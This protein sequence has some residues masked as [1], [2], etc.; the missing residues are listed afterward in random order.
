M[1]IFLYGADTFRSRQ[2]LNELKDK[3]IREVDP[4][5]NSLIAL[6]GRDVKM[7]QVNE[8]ISPSSLLTKK[9]LIVVEDIF[10][11]KEKT[12]FVD[13]LDF[14]KKRGKAL[15]DN[16]IIFW[17]SQIRTNKKG[18]PIVPD[19]VGREKVLTKEPIQL[20]KYL[21][22]QKYTQEFKLLSNVETAA[23]IKKQVEARGGTIT[24]KAIQLLVSLVGSDLWQINNEID[25]LINYRLGLEP[26]LI[27][28]ARKGKPAPIEEEDI[29]KLVRGSFD[30]N[31][32]ALTDAI[33]NKN[34]NLAVKLIED[35]YGAGLTDSYLINMIV[36][37]FR[38]LLQIRQAL[39][40]G[41]TS[42]K[43]ISALKL[44]PFVVQKSI[45]QVRNFNLA[46]LKNILKKLVE[47]DYTM[48]TGQA[49]ARTMLN[50]LIT[51]I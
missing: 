40:A 15:K 13:I 49:D 6:D 36:R 17:D 3:F 37:Q 7:E 43:I 10:L 47:I 42:R 12:I 45:N 1:L 18:S 32:F 31:I 24:H 16:I 5:G 41:F 39:D 11:N 28:E 35:Q 4:S 22:E 26:K 20:F 27:L 46:A 8:K 25:K 21:S 19:A 33:S 30:E 34:R 51:K 44:H 9:R 48:K 29:E 14:F 2:K 50:L 23:W 38:I